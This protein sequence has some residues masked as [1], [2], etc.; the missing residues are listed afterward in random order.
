MR[1]IPVAA[2]AFLWALLM[3]ETIFLME[4]ILSGL[5]AFSV[6]NLRLHMPSPGN[7]RWPQLKRTPRMQII[8]T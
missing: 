4:A 1:N 8:E 2:M 5:S 7:A 6:N 3:W